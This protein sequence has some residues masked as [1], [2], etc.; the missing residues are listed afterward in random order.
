MLVDFSSPKPNYLNIEYGSRLT[1]A[2]RS[3]IALSMQV[4]LMLTE[5]VGDPGSLYFTKVLHWMIEL[6]CSVRKAFLLMPNPFFTVHKSFRNFAY[7]GTCLIMS[8]RGMLTFTC[9]STSKMPSCLEAFFLPLSAW[10]NGGGMLLFIES[11]L[12]NTC[13]SSTSSFSL[14]FPSGL[15]PRCSSSLPLLKVIMA[16]TSSIFGAG[17]LA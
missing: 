10:R 5:M 17:S 9:L 16:W 15:G 13:S 12:M 1:L 14:V 6:T 11:Y 7:V 3:S 2:P 4:P 8:S